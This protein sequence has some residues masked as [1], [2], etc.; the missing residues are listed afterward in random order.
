M[1]L[2]S[3]TKLLTTG[4]LAAGLLLTGVGSA[5]A[6]TATTPNDVRKQLN[7][8]AAPPAQ[9]QTKK[10]SPAAPAAKPAPANSSV[11]AAAKTAQAKPANPPKPQGTAK[12][13]AVTPT[14]VA[15]TKPGA[16]QPGKAPQVKPVATALKTQKAVL[17]TATAKA[18]GKLAP[19][20]SVKPIP[21]V[22]SA[23]HAAM[24][25]PVAEHPVPRRDPFDPLVDKAKDTPAGPQAPLPA[26]KPGLVVSSLRVDGIVRDPNGMIAIVSNPQ[27]RVYFLREGDRLYDGDVEHITMEGISFHQSGK[28]AFGKPVEREV[29]KRL[30]PTPGEQQ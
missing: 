19:A 9:N 5:C 1:R 6:Q 23:P 22:A 24:V 14:S 28:D 25:I 15:L 11:S 3:T 17:P 16:A 12:V 20:A 8:P 27:M 4:I 2:Q 18:A 7:Q 29:T 21:A 30:Y 10:P 13:P 26:G